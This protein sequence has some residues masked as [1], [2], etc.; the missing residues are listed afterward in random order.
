MSGGTIFGQ[1]EE[2]CFHFL[3][4]VTEGAPGSTKAWSSRGSDAFLT[5]ASILVRGVRVTKASWARLLGPKSKVL[6]NLVSL[7]VVEAE[8]D[9]RDDLP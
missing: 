2:G 3:G 9:T 5:D 6:A 4:I 8:N 1:D 7:C